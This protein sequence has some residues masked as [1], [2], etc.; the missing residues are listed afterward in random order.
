MRPQ[1]DPSRV[2]LDREVAQF[3][4]SFP[5][6]ATILD[7]G[8]GD[9]RYKG[10]FDHCLYRSA[11]FK[12]VNKPYA[13]PTYICDLANIPV[14]S[15][16]IDG[17]LFSQVME[18]LRDPL[19]VLT[20]LRRLLKPDGRVLYTGPLWYEEHEVP[21][22]FYRYTQFGLKHLFTQAGL[23]VDEMHWLEGYMATVA[24]QLRRMVKYLPTDPEEIG[25][26]PD[27]EALI[28]LLKGFRH[29]ASEIASLASECD[30]LKRYTKTG[31]N[32]NYV[33]LL[34]ATPTTA[35]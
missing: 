17:V 34:R 5:P 16:S 25:G 24:H 32:I 15:G 2:W 13:E 18:H 10:H 1:F 29:L 11:D 35:C 21:Y 20:E 26:G 6:G 14:E 22:D 19:E 27:A 9:Q 30:I 12:Q 8:A 4:S 7:A 33:A 3:A 31:Y 28:K 23:I